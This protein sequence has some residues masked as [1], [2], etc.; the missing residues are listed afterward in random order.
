M[1]SKL[2]PSGASWAK[3]SRN[4]G[5][6]HQVQRHRR[7]TRICRP[8]RAC[9]TPRRGA[10]RA[11]VRRRRR[12]RLPAIRARARRRVRSPP[13]TIALRD[14]AG[15]VAARRA[16]RGD[17]GDEL[18]L[19]QRGH[20][21][22]AVLAVHRAAFQEDRRD[23]V[24][25][26]ADVGEQFRQQVTAALRHVPEMV[27]RIDDRQLRLQRCLGRP[28]RQ[29]RLQRGVCRDRRRHGS[30]PFDSPTR[31]IVVS[32]FCGQQA[33][34]KNTPPPTREGGVLL[35]LGHRVEHNHRDLAFGLAS[36]SRRRAARIPAT[37]PTAAR[38]P[39]P[40]RSA[41]CAFIFLVPT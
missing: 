34:K 21:A 38:V 10:G 13:P 9:P 3:P 33:S 35:A 2:R 37:S 22:R 7:G 8:L 40:S 4:F 41:R 17:A 20:L 29:P 23:D 39:R 11:D 24:V 16:H 5:S 32:S 25:P 26:A 28:L 19:A 6:Q 14:A 15:T 12:S 27:V 31:A 30:S 1:T 18:D 36:G